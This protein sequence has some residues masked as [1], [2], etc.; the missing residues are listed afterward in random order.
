M[1]ALTSVFTDAM[2]AVCNYRCTISFAGHTQSILVLRCAGSQASRP[3]VV[4]QGVCGAMAERQRQVREE[5]GKLTLMR[6][7]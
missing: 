2:R 6:C 4:L 1:E 5:I 7:C 3:H